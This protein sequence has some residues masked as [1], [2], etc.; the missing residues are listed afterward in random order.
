MLDFL[1]NRLFLRIFPICYMLFIWLQSSFF[2]PESVGNLPFHISLPILIMVGIGFELAHL[3]EFGL[4]YL[5]FILA[6]L[7]F[8]EIGKGKELISITLS[9]SY[10]LIDEIH[11][12]FVPFRSFSMGDLIKDIIGI[13]VMWW[14]I[15]KSYF[16]NKNSRFGVFLRKI[17]STV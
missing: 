9:V 16:I 7:S 10:S 15:H 12:I 3:F 1:R 8:G 13:T 14:I 17:S 4:L 11:Q 2:N 6:F 5:F